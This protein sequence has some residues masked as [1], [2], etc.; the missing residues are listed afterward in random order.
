MNL[1]ACPLPDLDHRS[2]NAPASLTA[3]TGYDDEG[4]RWGYIPIVCM[5]LEGLT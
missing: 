3:L 2:S 5:V 4:E 1:R